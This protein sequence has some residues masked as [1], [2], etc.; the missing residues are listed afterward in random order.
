MSNELE[1]RRVLVVGASVGIG[2]AIATAA[3]R[4]G[5][6]VVFAAR[7]REVLDEAIA[8]AGGGVAAC[9]DVCAPQGCQAIV[10]QAVAAVGALTV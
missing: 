7:R 1:G 8:E 3:V 5:A 4:Q 2:R 9:G 6:E 10:D